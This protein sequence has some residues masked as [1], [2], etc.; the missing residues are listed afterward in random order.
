MIC[1][2]EFDYETGRRRKSI[3]FFAE[4]VLLAVEGLNSSRLSVGAG[5]VERPDCAQ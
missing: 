2:M 3:Y 5:I 4:P 1:R